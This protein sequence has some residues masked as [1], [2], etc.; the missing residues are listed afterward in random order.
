MNAKIIKS[1]ML[2]VMATTLIVATTVVARSLVSESVPPKIPSVV[3]AQSQNAIQ[4]EQQ[5]I[6][7]ATG[8]LAKKVAEEYPPGVD[9]SNL[10]PIKIN[11]ITLVNPYAMVEWF[12]GGLEGQ[13]LLLKKQA[14]W[15]VALSG[16]GVLTTRYL[17]E[18]GIPVDTAKALVQRHQE[19][20]KVSATILENNAP[21]GL[22]ACVPTRQ[23]A[24]A[25]LVG[26]AKHE[27]M[28]YYLFAAYPEPD[29]ISADLLISTNSQNRCLL[30]FYNPWGEITSL[31]RVAP[32]EVV[33]SLAL[34]RLKREVSKFGGMSAYQQFLN[35]G[36]DIPP[37][38][39]PEEV[40]ALQ[41][42][43]IQTRSVVADPKG[44]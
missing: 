19:G 28:T 43:G 13:A 41:Q 15:V 21:Q 16:S 18:T 29:T 8:Y 7:V 24:K 12:W 26:T 34:Q 40:W 32:T 38:R 5:I 22:K 14:S 39:T 9:T 6:K 25:T 42:L 20:S 31:S 23:V 44:N 11:G 3:V 33:R 30:L 4:D 27:G 1:L 10:P 36:A 2:G 35:T 37:R 17:V